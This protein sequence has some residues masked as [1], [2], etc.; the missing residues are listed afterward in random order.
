VVGVGNC[1]VLH[2]L[3]A[4]SEGKTSWVEA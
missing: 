2:G 3:G 4:L 1:T